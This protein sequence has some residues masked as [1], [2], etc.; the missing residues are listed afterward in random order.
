MD[1]NSE[2]ATVVHQRIISDL[3]RLERLLGNTIPNDDQGRRV[4]EALDIHRRHLG[5]L[6]PIAMISDLARIQAPGQN[7]FDLEP[8]TTME[9]QDEERAVK[10]A[11]DILKEL[12]ARG[13]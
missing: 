2:S 13:E 1:Q 8:K 12:N 4:R 10:Y 3:H 6:A 7:V 5:I 11:E 9:P